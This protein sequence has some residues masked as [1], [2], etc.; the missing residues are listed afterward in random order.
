VSPAPK[1]SAHVV[2]A[3]GGVAALEALIALRDLAGERVRI[4]LVAPAPGFVYRPM[5]V[6]EPFGLGEARRHPLREIAAEFGAALVPASVVAVDAHERRVVCRSGDELRYDRLVLAPGARTLDA[7]DDAITFGGPHAGAALRE[8]LARLRRGEA[9]RA[10]FVVPSRVGWPLPLYEL[11]LMTAA[12]LRAHG[13]TGADLSL[14]TPEPR[15]LDVFG[16]GPSDMVAGL[17]AA[18]GVEALTG[19]QAD[20]AA[21]ALVLG[22]GGPRLPVDAVVSLPLIRGVEIDGVPADPVCGFIPVDAYGRVRGLPFVHAAGDATD[23]PVK[24]GG[25]A[26]QQADAVA[27]DIAAQLGAPVAP[28]PFRP[29]LRGVLLTGAGPRSGAATPEAAGALWRPASKIAGR[30]LAPYLAER[31]RLAGAGTAPGEVV[32]IA[33]EP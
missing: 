12:D 7:F 5:S 1:T 16:A 24:H 28:E 25:L 2:I 23:F 19:T 14:V 27:R 32:E 3:G 10:A 21:G 33:L 8:L 31:D 20:I 4:T 29:V 15:P 17:L 6:A 13:V 22:A 30:Y 26:A 11:A 9:R 18:A